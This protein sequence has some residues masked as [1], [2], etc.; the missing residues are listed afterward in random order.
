M[1]VTIENLSKKPVLLRLNSGKTLHLAPN[2]TSSEL[3]DAEVRS[4]T[5]VQKL[6]DRYVIALHEVR[7]KGVPP[8]APKKEKA[9]STEGT[10]KAKVEPTKD[11]IKSPI[12][13]GGK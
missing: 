7:K 1:P 13:K 3:R 2:K 5:K 9:E 8:D 12:L 6:Q 10:K 4:N 11:K